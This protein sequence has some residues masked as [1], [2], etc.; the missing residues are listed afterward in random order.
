MAKD[1]KPT[2]LTNVHV[3]VTNLRNTKGSGKA[4][5]IQRSGATGTGEVTP[6]KARRA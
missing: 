1:P 6:R 2:T 5:Q 4:T 3:N